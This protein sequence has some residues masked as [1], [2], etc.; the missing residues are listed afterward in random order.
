MRSRAL[1][2]DAPPGGVVVWLLPAAA[3]LVALLAA[4]SVGAGGPPPASLAFTPAEPPSR[5]RPVEPP[6][7]L[8]ADVPGLPAPLAAA[9]ARRASP[10]VLKQRPAR[11]AA[12][13]PTAVPTPAPE[14]PAAPAPTQ[15]QPAAAPQSAAPRPVTPAPQFDDSGSGPVF[16][17]DGPTP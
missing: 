8:L 16:D 17:E 6:T 3:F 1:R 12:A 2:P 10:V 9:P 7:P 5:G 4:A 11:Q 15:R 14:V 13:A